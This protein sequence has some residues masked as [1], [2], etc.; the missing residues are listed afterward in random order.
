MGFLP[1]EAVLFV[2]TKKMDGTSVLLKDKLIELSPEYPCPFNVFD[3][4]Q[5]NFLRRIFFSLAY[6]IVVFYKEDEPQE[7]HFQYPPFCQ[8]DIFKQK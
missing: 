3:F 6:F 1:L 2:S 8:L 7:L 5:S 4:E